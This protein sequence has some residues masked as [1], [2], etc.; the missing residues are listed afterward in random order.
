MTSKRKR[1]TYQVSYCA[2]TKKSNIEPH[3]EKI[4]NS[5]YSITTLSA[6]YCFLF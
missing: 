1:K 2:V 3:I 5:Q 6:E 4:Y